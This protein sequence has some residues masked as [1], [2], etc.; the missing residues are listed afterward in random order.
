MAEVILTVKHGDADTFTDVVS[1]LASLSGYTAKMYI[2]DSDG[3]LVLTLTGSIDTLTITYQL[4]NDACKALSVAKYY[5]ESKV[6][7]TSDHVYTTSWGLFEIT[8]AKN[9]DPS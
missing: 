9:S 8:A 1:N 5:Y 3:D 7:D 2:Y 6:F 4:T